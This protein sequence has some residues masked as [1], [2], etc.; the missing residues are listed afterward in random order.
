MK[1]LHDDTASPV[2]AELVESQ[3]SLEEWARR[4][5]ALTPAREWNN[6]PLFIDFRFVDP[7]VI[8]PPRVTEFTQMERQRVERTP[9]GEDFC[10]DTI[11]E[12]P[13]EGLLKY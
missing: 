3:G 1:H 12:A 9:P 7:S 13:Y 10:N 2:R 6:P 11:L 8:R 4:K 5:N